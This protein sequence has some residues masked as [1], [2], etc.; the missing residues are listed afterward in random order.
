MG[1]HTVHNTT[2][3]QKLNYYYY[4]LKRV[5]FQCN[6]CCHVDG[7]DVRFF[8]VIFADITAR[9]SSINSSVTDAMTLNKNHK[10]GIN[11]TIYSNV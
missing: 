4:K 3:I 2:K 9:F 6:L 5:N 11:W 8:R 10:P 7:I 1:G